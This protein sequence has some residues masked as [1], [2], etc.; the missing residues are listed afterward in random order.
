VAKR[1]EPQGGDLA[2][3][4]LRFAT[5]KPLGS[6]DAVQWFMRHGANSF[7][8]D[9][10]PFDARENW[11]EENSERLAAAGA[12]PLDHVDFW[13]AAEK[14]FQALAFCCEWAAFIKSD[15]SLGFA[16]GLPVA[17]DGSCNGFQHLAAL[18]RDPAAA[19]AVNL[20]PNS[21][22]QDLYQR[23]L[24][25]VKGQ[26]SGLDDEPMAREWLES[27][28]LKRSLVKRPVMTVPYGVSPRGIAEQ[29]MQA[30]N[31]AEAR[32]RFKNLA[33]AANFLADQIEKSLGGVLDRANEVRDYLVRLASVIGGGHLQLGWWI[34]PSGFKVFTDY[35]KLEKLEVR[36]PRRRTKI[37]YRIPVE[38]AELD[39][40]KQKAAIV[41]NLIHSL[42]AAHLAWTVASAVKQR[43]GMAFATVHDSFATHAADADFL[44]RELR[45]QFVAIYE[46]IPDDPEYFFPFGRWLEE[47][48][49]RL[50]GA[51]VFDGDMTKLPYPPEPGDFDIKAVLDSPYFFS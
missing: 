50:P 28:L 23:V 8:L 34:A 1:L 17:M 7:G 2:K 37:V 21:R 6:R 43:P 26:L 24:D 49:S 18:T 46:P 48:H 42:D 10:E 38:H 36:V 3:G 25:R 41:A 16:S 40:N 45:E 33:R 27:G 30:V 12:R 20:A 19:E 47:F 15:R 9:K 14:P 11:V 31:D 51:F 44:A 35:R 13:K 5:A 39:A 22:P 32:E 29:L 4:L